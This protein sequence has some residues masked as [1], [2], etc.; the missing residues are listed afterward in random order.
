MGVS[1]QTKFWQGDFGDEY[2]DRNKIAADDR[3]AFFARLL[4]R[5]FGVARICEYGANKGHN[6]EAISR[7]SPNFD[8]TGVELNEKACAAMARLAHVRAVHA[9]LLEYRPERPF[10]LTFVCGVL[11][12]LNPDD[13]PAAYRQ[14]Y[15]TSGR[16]IL[17]NEYFNPVSVEVAYRGHQGRLF[18]RDFGGEF[19]DL[20][21]DRVRLVDYGFLWKR[22]EPAWDDTTWWLFERI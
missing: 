3:Q 8:L 18:K 11:I 16:Y 21:R 7:L 15:E 1:E 14:L 4:S 9:S 6:L 19:W 5:T 2:T 10:D 22:V 13:L 20:H 12:H 17:I